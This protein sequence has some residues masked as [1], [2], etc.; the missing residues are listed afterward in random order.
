MF[1]TRSR[2][3]A[4]FDGSQHDDPDN[5]EEEEEEEVAGSQDG[6]SSDL[7]DAPGSEAS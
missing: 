3:D 7:S 1:E 4:G 2:T 5:E 6:S